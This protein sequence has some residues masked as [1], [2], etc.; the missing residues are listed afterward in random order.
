MIFFLVIYKLSNIHLFGS[1]HNM[2]Y[3]TWILCVSKTNHFDFIL[4]VA[5]THGH[6]RDNDPFSMYSLNDSF[7]ESLIYLENQC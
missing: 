7:T 4:P 1:S 2:Y 3:Y 5:F 6:A